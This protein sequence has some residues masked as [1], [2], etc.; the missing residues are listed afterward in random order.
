MTR[1]KGHA[2]RIGN[3]T[4]GGD[5]PAVVQ[6]M[7]NTD[8]ADTLGAEAFQQLVEAYVENRYGLARH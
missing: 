5:V 4:L 7:T 1:R 6:S 8:T 3:V 2:V